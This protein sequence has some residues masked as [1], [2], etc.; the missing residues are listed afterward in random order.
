LLPTL[1]VTRFCVKLLLVARSIEKEVSLLAFSVQLRSMR[2]LETTV[3][4]RSLGAAGGAG[5]SVV[6]LMTPE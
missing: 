3:P 4:L 6:R 1:F 5:A 2:V